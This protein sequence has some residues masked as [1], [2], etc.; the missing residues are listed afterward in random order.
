MC[1]TRRE[2]GVV[3]FVT[4]GICGFN[5]EPLV[6]PWLAQIVGVFVFKL[7]TPITFQLVVLYLLS[8]INYSSRGSHIAKMDLAMSTD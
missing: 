6:A 1:G 2:R 3:G 7:I 5:V 8:L 4:N